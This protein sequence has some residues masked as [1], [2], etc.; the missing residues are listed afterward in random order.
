MAKQK[1]SKNHKVEDAEDEA[2]NY[3][4]VMYKFY[5]QLE[6]EFGAAYIG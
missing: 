1:R 2:S 5:K 3:R 4:E 6:T